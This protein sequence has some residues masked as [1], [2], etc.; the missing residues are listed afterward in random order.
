MR[1]VSVPTEHMNLKLYLEGL[2]ADQVV[3]ED[4]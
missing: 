4:H 1:R 2:G 3:L